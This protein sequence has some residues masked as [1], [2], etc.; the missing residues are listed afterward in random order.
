MKKLVLLLIAVIAMFDAAKAQTSLVA[1]LS[2]DGTVS[3]YYSANALKDAYEAAV[4]GDVVT[5]SSGSFAA[6]ATIAKNITVRGAGMM[7]DRESTVIS[8]VC[9]IDVIDL[10]SANVVT[11]EGLHFSSELRLLATRNAS[12]IKCRLQRLSHTPSN[13][14]KVSNLRIIHSLI[15]DMYL[16]TDAMISNSYFPGGDYSTSVLTVSNC[17]IP[18][19]RS[20]VLGGGTISN[21]VLYGSNNS[22]LKK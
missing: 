5:L 2:H 19:R 12:I 3:T 22:S 13:S 17:V 20:I 10:E 14:D 18:T 16:S 8:G 4:D 1:T 9:K 6:P 15:E 11:L 7:L 21:S